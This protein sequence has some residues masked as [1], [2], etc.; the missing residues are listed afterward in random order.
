M[1]TVDNIPLQDLVNSNN[2]IIN[3]MEEICIGNGASKQVEQSRKA[4][5]NTTEEYNILLPNT[6]QETQDLKTIIHYPENKKIP[7]T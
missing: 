4:F 6:N 1:Y 5:I 2:G 7:F 3:R